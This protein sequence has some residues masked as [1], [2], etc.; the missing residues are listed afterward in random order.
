MKYIKLT[1]TPFLQK[2]VKITPIANNWI[3]FKWLT[4]GSKSEKKVHFTVVAYA[5]FFIYRS[6]Y[7][8]LNV[9]FL[10][11]ACLWVWRIKTNHSRSSTVPQIIYKYMLHKQ[12][13]EV[14]ERYTV[15]VFM[16]YNENLKICRL[17]W[18]IPATIYLW[19]FAT[20]TSQSSNSAN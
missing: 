19:N 13:W 8:L 15:L 17:T 5:R 3:N 12:N 18:S 7:S 14:L 2:S 10:C 4:W 1:K 6:I 16:S 20:K 9:S 11:F